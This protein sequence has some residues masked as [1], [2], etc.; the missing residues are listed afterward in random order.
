MDW[1]EKLLEAA[2]KGSTIRARIV[3][4]FGADINTTNNSGWTALMHTAENGH[5]KTAEML[6]KKGAYVNAKNRWGETALMW[7]ASY[8][9]IRIAEFLIQNGA[10][11]NAK[12]GFGGTALILA[13]SYEHKKTVKLL[14]RKGA[15]VVCACKNGSARET[16]NQLAREKPELFTEKQRIMLNLY[17]NPGKFSINKKKKVIEV[18]RELQKNGSISKTEA[19]ELFKNLQRMWNNNENIITNKGMRKPTKE[20]KKERLR[21]I[22]N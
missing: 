12:G 8:G 11:I 14:I 4:F 6:I 2:K 16:I 9:Y 13:A 10:D 1:D 15:N 5:T 7:A 18:L 3:L 17:S 21:K 19:L 22:I 20:L